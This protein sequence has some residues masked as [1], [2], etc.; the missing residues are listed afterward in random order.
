MFLEMF[1][2]GPDTVP[3]TVR[4]FS[5][6]PVPGLYP[7]VSYSNPV[8]TVRQPLLVQSTGPVGEHKNN[9]ET[10]M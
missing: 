8:D 5:T 4:R 3:V 6:A 1:Q 10:F 7:K 9:G 2:N